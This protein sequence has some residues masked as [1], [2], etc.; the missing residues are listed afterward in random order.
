[1]LG[2]FGVLHRPSLLVLAL[3]VSSALYAAAGEQPAPAVGSI[4]A[5]AASLGIV[6]V[7]G[8]TSTLVVQ[9]EGKNY[10]VDLGSRSVHEI[11]P[12]PAQPTSSSSQ[13]QTPPPDQ[14]ETTPKYYVPGNDRLFILPTG[15]RL[16][17]HGMSVSFTHRFPYEAAFT[18]PA[19]GHTLLGLDDLSISGLG[20]QYGVTSRLSMSVYRAPS[21]IGRPIELMAAYIVSEERTGNPLTATLRFSVDGQDDFQRN[22]TTNF[23]AILSR[24]I[25]SRAAVYL[26]P[27]F[28]YHNRPLLSATSS[29]SD[30]PQYQPCR[31]ALANGLPPSF[32]VRPCANTFSLG[33]GLAVDVRPTVALIVEAIPTLANGEDLGIHRPPFSFA[34]QKKIWRHAFTFGFTTAPGTTVAQRAGTR[35]T[36]RHDPNADTPAGLFV[37][38]NL[39]RQFR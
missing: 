28:S 38:F 17:R 3:V 36:F 18:G 37:G 31:Q 39:S 22:F 4:P 16:P 2:H 11:E 15:A 7:D 33:V 29:L 24:S 25:T 5:A 26:V 13:S 35:A 19:R 12:L 6:F 34:I 9:R 20:F 10:L 23:E 14:Q 30:P 8:S 27:T 32:R 1:M 21:I